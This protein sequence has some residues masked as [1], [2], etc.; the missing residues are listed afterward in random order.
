MSV[1]M[2]HGQAQD[3]YFVTI[4]GGFDGP[5][6]VK[7]TVTAS[8]AVV[9]E[10]LRQVQHIHHRRLNRL[11]VGLDV[12]WRP[13]FGRGVD[14]PPAILQLCVGRR[15]LVFQILHADYVPDLLADFLE[16]KRFTFVGVGVD[17][18]VD[19]LDSHWALAVG[20]TR[21]LRHLVAEASH[22]PEMR[23]CGLAGLAEEVMGLDRMTKDRNVTLSRWDQRWL[24]REQ[25]M[26]AVT[27][28]FLSFEIGR[29][30][31]AG[32]YPLFS[33]NI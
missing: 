1:S 10:W 23:G 3:A 9:E 12:E 6:K 16:D 20:R 2:E 14:N 4:D 7:G 21:D 31:I 17:E 32:N 15:C 29:R 8:G 30:V 26:Y 11:V 28:G 22:Q 19:K 33:V 5:N 24:S 25:I 27:D 13:N 18:D